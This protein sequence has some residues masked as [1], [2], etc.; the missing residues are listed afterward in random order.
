M[1]G[2]T[3]KIKGMNCA[4]LEREDFDAGPTDLD[5]IES[6]LWIGEFLC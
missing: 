3:N 5:C 2:S 1:E 4:G 6:G